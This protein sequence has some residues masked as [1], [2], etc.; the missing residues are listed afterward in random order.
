MRAARPVKSWTRAWGLMLFSVGIFHIL[1]AQAQEDTLTDRAEQGDD[2]IRTSLLPTALLLTQASIALASTIW[3]VNGVNGSDSH[4]CRSSQ[5]ACK[6]IG[7][8]VSLTAS[9]DSIRVAAAT[10]AENITIASSLNLIGSG[11][12]TT[13]ID[14]GRKN[15]VVTVPTVGSVVSISNVT[16]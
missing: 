3:Y 4:N 16:R 14:G 1:P 2:R 9:G 6:T 13:I 11:A 10:Y 5:T 7:H 15:R 12:S 8:A